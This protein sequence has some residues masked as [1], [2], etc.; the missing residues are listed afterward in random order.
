M[1]CCHVDHMEDHAHLTKTRGRR[2]PPSPLPLPLAT[3]LLALAPVAPGG[4]QEA[5]RDVVPLLSLPDHRGPLA[6]GD[7]AIPAMEG[8][9]EFGELLVI[10]RYSNWQNWYFGWDTSAVWTDNVALS[11][12]DPEEDTYL[13]NVATLSYLPAITGNLFANAALRQEVLRYDENPDLD[14]EYMQAD[15]A[16]MYVPPASGGRLDFLKQD[17]ALTAGYGYYRVSENDFDDDLLTDHLA[18]ASVQKVLRPSVGHELTLGAIAEFSLD[19]DPLTSSRHEYR[20]YAGYTVDWTRR[21]TT[22]LMYTG[23]YHDYRGSGRADWNRYLGGNL[24]ITLLEGF[25]RGTAWRLALNI[26]ANYS[27]NDSNEAELD[28][29]SLSV[30]GG[31]GLH[32][33]F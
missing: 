7:P 3:L 28:Y 23:A 26:H 2:R 25:S 32:M 19:G 15:L 30:G 8:D 11:P 17:M 18:H 12:A 20:W 33:N 5:A 22:G 27:D 24:R 31:L 29:H 10:E 13:L 4:A 9:D 14:F 21:I 16:L 1:L 6:G